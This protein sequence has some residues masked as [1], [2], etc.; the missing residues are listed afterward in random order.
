MKNFIN[1]LRIQK[2]GIKL[3]FT[4]F[5]LAMFG[6][7]QLVQVQAQ[8]TFQFYS[9]N[10]DISIPD[11]D[12]DG[13][14]SSMVSKA[15]TVSGIPSEMHFV[16]A[17]NGIKI[18][19]SWAGDL[20]VKL[21]DDVGFALGLMSRPGLIETAD[22]GTECCGANVL[23]DGTL[24]F[25]DDAAL[26]SED[27]GDLGTPVPDNAR[28]IPSKGAI[29]SSWETLQDFFG[30]MT[31]SQINGTTWYCAVGD[32]ESGDTGTFNSAYLLFTYDDY[33]VAR[34]VPDEYISNVT[35]AG[36]NNDTTEDGHDYPSYF[37]DITTYDFATVKQGDV[38]TLTVSIAPDASDYVYAYIDWNQN[39]VFEAD[40]T[41]TIIEN[42]ELSGPFSIS[43]PVPEDAVI[44]Q[45]RMRV[46]LNYNKPSPDPCID[47]SWGETEDY[48][49]KV[50]EAMGLNENSLSSISV[51][52]NPVKDIL[53]ITSQKNVDKAEIYNLSG[54]LIQT[55][56]ATNQINM[57]TLP[58]GI[59]ILKVISADEVQTFKIVKK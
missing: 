6:F 36:V 20:T 57:E 34:L 44:G 41:Y 18:Q 50:E 46:S 1:Y 35:F 25:D 58:A 54:Q 29:N 32:S 30:G 12:Y 59:Y 7:G 28:V 43:I 51:Y 31:P 56:K 49:V 16:K 8:E 14:F 11:N 19:H 24:I 4:Y 23:L 40:E 21:F 13:T 47:S 9:D 10:V 33:C 48:I 37:T 52:P 38:Y 17:E 5:C 55:E 22:D 27:L 3:S 53:N 39:K 15:I 26:E 45:T 2:T 42:T